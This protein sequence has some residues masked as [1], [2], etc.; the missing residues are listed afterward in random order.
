MLGAPN[1]TDDVWLYGNTMADVRQTLLKGRN[2]RMPAFGEQL[3]A[4]RIHLLSAYV[5]SL[6]AQ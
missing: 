1:L 2:G 6:N 5:L 3:D 4:D